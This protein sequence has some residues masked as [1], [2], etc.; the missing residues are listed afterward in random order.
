MTPEIEYG[1]NLIR[2][3]S[4]ESNLTHW[5]SNGVTVIAGGV[6]GAKCFRLSS[7]ATLRQSEEYLAFV[8]A[9]ATFKVKIHHKHTAAQGT[10][11]ANIR[12]F[13]TLRITYEDSTVPN[14]TYILPLNSQGTLGK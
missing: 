5:T 2:N 1:N 7:D 4:A 10:L 3:P 11:Y 14:S 13:C 12:S 6:E 8:V 9:P